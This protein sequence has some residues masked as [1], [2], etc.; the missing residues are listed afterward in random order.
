MEREAPS[1]FK[2]LTTRFSL[3]LMLILALLLGQAPVLSNF[4][5]W[6]MTFF[7]EISHGLVTLLT[8]GRILGIELHFAG[9]GLC[10]V[11]GGVR[12]LAALA[13]YLGATVWGV[14]IYLLAGIISKKYSHLLAAFLVVGLI[15]SAILYVRDFQSGII[16]LFIA[17][18]YSAAVKF[19]DQLPLH[20]LLKLSGLYII[21]DALK[22]PL[23]L[24][25]YPGPND[26]ATLAALTG[27]PAFVWIVLWLAAALGGLILIWKI[28]RAQKQ[29]R[30]SP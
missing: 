5:S 8:G 13:G 29:T 15:G 2:R 23:V 17:I 7:H 3:P 10:Q 30:P 22:A 18:W 26:A 25:G 6:Q 9:S 14:L 16:I 20:F 28:E 27:L 11:S 24:F 12:W 19:R 4:L 1:I 21:L